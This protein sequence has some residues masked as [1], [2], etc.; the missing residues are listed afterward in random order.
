IICL[1]T[2]QNRPDSSPRVP[3]VGLTPLRAFVWDKLLVKEV[4][5]CEANLPCTCQV[6]FPDPNKLHC[7]QL[8]VTPDEGNHRGGGTFPHEC[9]LGIWHP[10][11]AKTGEICLSL[12]R[13]HSTD[14]TSWTSIEIFKDVVWGLNKLFTVLLT[15]DGPLNIKAAEHI[16][17]TKRTSRIMLKTSLNLMAEDRK[18][19]L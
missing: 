14:C 5:K 4:T 2:K 18:R 6:H 10:N 19:R 11:S 1:F 15:C 9:L 12:P 3:D 16:C 13:D 8:T 7:F 17:R